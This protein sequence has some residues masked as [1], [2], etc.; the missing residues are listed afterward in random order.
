MKKLVIDFTNLNQKPFVFWF[1]R[2]MISIWFCQEST[3]KTRNIF[4]LQKKRE[5]VDSI[6]NF[7]IFNTYH[8]IFRFRKW[9]NY[10]KMPLYFHKKN[11]L[12]FRSDIYTFVIL[13]ICPLSTMVNNITHS[14]TIHMKLP[15]SCRASTTSLIMHF[16]VIAYFN[17]IMTLTCLIALSI[18]PLRDWLRCS[19]HE[20]TTNPYEN[21]EKH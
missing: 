2:I 15:V 14:H 1:T 7:L 10:Y 16:D 3:I 6:T 11:K 8:F 21:H 17:Q 9:N 4:S 19:L 20:D 5:N 13:I 12:T 18:S